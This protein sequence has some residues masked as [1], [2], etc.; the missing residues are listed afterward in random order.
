MA[1]KL[2][3][4]L[5]TINQSIDSVFPTEEPADHTGL[6]AAVMVCIS[7]FAMM[8]I[9][10]WFQCRFP[11]AEKYQRL[12]NPLLP[13]YTDGAIVASLETSE[14]DDDEEDSEPTAL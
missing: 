9:I 6:F 5:G 3:A 2:K 1:E 7:V 14:M 4:Y 12:R 10:A 11:L 8:V 13:V